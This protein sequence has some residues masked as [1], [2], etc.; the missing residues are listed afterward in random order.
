MS[1]RH[2]KLLR[3]VSMYRRGPVAIQLMSL[4]G[5]KDCRKWA[6]DVERILSKDLEKMLVTAASSFGDWSYAVNYSDYPIPP[7]KVRESL[8]DIVQSAINGYVIT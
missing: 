6:N 4:S 5:N 3:Q 1:K 2:R 7:E 8:Y